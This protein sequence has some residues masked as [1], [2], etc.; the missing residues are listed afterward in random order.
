MYDVEKGALLPLF[1]YFNYKV[2]KPV[3]GATNSDYNF[4]HIINYK[5]LKPQMVITE[6]ALLVVAV[7]YV[8]FYFT[9][10]HLSQSMILLRISTFSMDISLCSS[11]I[12]LIFS[13]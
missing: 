8:P 13:Y 10:K 1:L 2:L 5:V 6:P 3:S 12:R 9:I 7:I 11:R 4:G